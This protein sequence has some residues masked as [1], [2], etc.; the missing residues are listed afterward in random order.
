MY[1]MLFLKNSLNKFPSGVAKR[2]NEILIEL[3]KLIS[4]MIDKNIPIYFFIAL[5]HTLNKIISV[6]Y[7]L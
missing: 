4:F 6:K 1:S 5:A 3:S 7:L 2:G